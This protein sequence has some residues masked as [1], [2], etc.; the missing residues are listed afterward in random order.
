MQSTELQQMMAH[1]EWADATIWTSVLAT[2]ACIMDPRMRG[3]LVH[4]HGVQW[5]YLQLW[6]SEPLD[7]PAVESFPTLVAVAEWARHYHDQRAE[8]TAGLA[9]ADLERHIHFPWAERLAERFGTVFPTT[10]RQ[11]IMQIALHSSYHRGQVNARLR[12]LGGE[13]PLVDFVAWVWAGAP[14][15]KWPQLHIAAIRP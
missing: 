14:A 11:S 1:L 8:F 10:L 15:P 9:A 5:A 13:P 6:R 12:E 7:M 3:L 2:P 4:I